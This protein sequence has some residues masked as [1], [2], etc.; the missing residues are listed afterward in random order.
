[1]APE[2]S[3]RT[4]SAVGLNLSDIG[5]FVAH[6]GLSD[7]GRFVALTL[8]RRKASRGLDGLSYSAV[9]LVMISLEGNGLIVRKLS[10]V[11]DQ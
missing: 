5:L 9:S 1:M 6:T 3:V 7:I 11:S 2:R 10:S 4:E 8:P